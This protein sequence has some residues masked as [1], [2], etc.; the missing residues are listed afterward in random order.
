MIAVSVS[1]STIWVETLR[2][3]MA[4]HGWIALQGVCLFST[5]YV[6]FY[7]AT[8]MLTSGLVALLFS[9]VAVANIFNGAL[10]LGNRI[11][12]RVIF[13]ALMGVGGLALVFLPELRST[14]FSTETMI[15]IAHCVFG[16]LFASLGMILSARNQRVCL[17]CHAPGDRQLRCAR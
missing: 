9:M 1:S 15:G 13:G 2:V 11:E 3:P 10:F 16:T 7:Y 5:N 8:S 12:A 6:V 14:S 4:T 17:K